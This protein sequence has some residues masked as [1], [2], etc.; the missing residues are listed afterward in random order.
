MIASWFSGAFEFWFGCKISLNALKCSVQRHCYSSC[1]CWRLQTKPLFEYTVK[2][3]CR[4]RA[5][6]A[7]SINVFS[8]NCSIFYQRGSL[9]FWVVGYGNIF[10]CVFCYVNETAAVLA[11]SSMD[12]RARI[13]LQISWH[14]TWH[15]SVFWVQLSPAVVPILPLT[16]RYS[17]RRQQE[18]FCPNSIN[19]QN[20]QQKITPTWELCLNLL[21]GFVLFV[22]LSWDAALSHLKS[23][24]YPNFFP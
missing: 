10:L 7:T 20:E 1:R 11:A 16:Y 8:L 6:C 9:C 17:S 24:C 19:R 3:H 22:W 18:R 5:R 12:L 4:M 23:W 2:S 21:N 14:L 13:S 15:W